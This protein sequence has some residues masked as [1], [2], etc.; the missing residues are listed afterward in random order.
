MELLH[1][2]KTQIIF[3]QIQPVL[4]LLKS[5]KIHQNDFF[6][7]SKVFFNNIELILK[8]KHAFTKDFF[9]I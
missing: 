6:K 2:P 1:A 4:K 9:L 7:K 3:T 5:P 8:Q